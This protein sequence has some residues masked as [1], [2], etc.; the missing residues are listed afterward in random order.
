MTCEPQPAATGVAATSSD[1][2]A[3]TGRSAGIPTSPSQ[4]AKWRRVDGLSIGDRAGRQ[5]LIAASRLSTSGVL[6][7]IWC[8]VGWR[9]KT[10]G[11]PESRSSSGAGCEITLKGPAVRNRPVSWRPNVS[12]WPLRIPVEGPDQPPCPRL[13]AGACAD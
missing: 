13:V 5:M 1:R 9:R 7:A 3:R 11:V 8:D 6:Y 12:P 2:P 4:R 10:T